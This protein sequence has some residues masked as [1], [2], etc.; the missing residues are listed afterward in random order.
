ML[1]LEEQ[2]RRA[3]IAGDTRQAALLRCIVDIDAGV[4]WAPEDKDDEPTTVND[5]LVGGALAQVELDILLRPDPRALRL[6]ELESII[7]L[8]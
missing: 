7:A 3:Y 2:E 1:T 4:I 6:A 8:A 5:D